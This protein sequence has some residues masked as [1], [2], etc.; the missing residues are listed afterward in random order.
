MAFTI[1]APLV[2]TSHHFAL[3]LNVSAVVF[4]GLQSYGTPMIGGGMSAY[5]NA[6]SNGQGVFLSS[7]RVS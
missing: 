6:D 2:N 7:I 5:V 4:A 3:V 1:D